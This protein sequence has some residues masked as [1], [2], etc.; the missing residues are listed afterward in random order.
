MHSSITA[1]HILVVFV[2][3]SRGILIFVSILVMIPVLMVS[4]SVGTVLQF[5]Q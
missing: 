4:V 5:V 3:I 1:M 2:F